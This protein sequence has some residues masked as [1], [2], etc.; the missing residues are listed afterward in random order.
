MFQNGWEGGS[1]MRERCTHFDDDETGAAVVGALE[2]DG[3][4]VVGD[5]EALDRGSF[6]EV[7][8]WSCGYKREGEKRGE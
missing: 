5:V 2:I 1:E 7:F 6:L 3:A 4:L 8:G